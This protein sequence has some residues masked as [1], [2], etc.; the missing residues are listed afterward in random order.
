MADFIHRHWLTCALWAWV[1]S[2]ASAVPVFFFSSLVLLIPGLALAGTLCVY[3][4][5]I[6]DH[7]VY[8]RM[9]RE[10]ER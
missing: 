3:V 6:A 7:V 1:A 5:A 10:Q 2:Y 4:G 9:K 8:R